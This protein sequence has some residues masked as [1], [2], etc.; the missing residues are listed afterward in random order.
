MT[1]SAEAG[2]R[3]LDNLAKLFSGYEVDAAITIN[4]FYAL[5]PM[6]KYIFKPTGE[7]WPAESINTR[8]PPKLSMDK[9][10]VH[11]RGSIGMRR[12]NR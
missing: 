5:M 3:D 8:L 7:L 1:A 2:I 12:W 4:D 10:C 11:P 9:S 6:H